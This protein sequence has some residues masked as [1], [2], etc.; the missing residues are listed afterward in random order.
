MQHPKLKRILWQSPAVIALI[1]LVLRLLGVAVSYRGT[2]NTYENHLYFGFETGRIARSI[3]EGHGFG[4]PMFIETGPTAWLTPV[5]PFLLAASFKV[6]GV[7]SKTSAFV[8]LGLNS[9]FSAVVCVPIFFIAKRSFGRSVA[10]AAC[11]IWALFPYFIF[12]PGG[13]V[14]DTCLGALL[15]SILFLWT[16]KLREQHSLGR[17]LGYGL[18]WGFCALTN[19]STLSL[20][21]FLSA[22]AL[23]P[24]R[25]NRQAWLKG[26]LLV[27]AGLGVVLLPWEVRNYRTFHAPIPLRDT[28]WL[29]FW[30]GNDGQTRTWLDASVHPSTNP[31]EQARFAQLGEISYMREKRR[32]ALGF[33][34]HHPGLYVVTCL[35]RFGY[36]WTGFWN[37]DPSNLQDEFHSFANVYLTSSMTLAMLLGFWQAFRTARQ[38]WLPY[39]FVLAFYPLLFYLTHPTIRYRHVIDPEV[40]ILAALGVKSLL[41]ALRSSRAPIS[42]PA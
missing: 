4:N 41:S 12:I 21:P 22:W 10:V 6:F 34:T 27:T 28:F 18:L 25:Q 13:F 14:W 1:A 29:E 5:Y 24:M 30:V 20:W 16:L 2:W 31:E 26:A 8:I 37:M 32:Q 39:L 33:L 38:T 19:A 42:R 40:A 3:A 36:L 7:Y 35:R 23:Y 17:W 11:W 9:L 15:V